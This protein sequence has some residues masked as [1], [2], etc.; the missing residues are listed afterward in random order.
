MDTLAFLDHVQALPSYSGQ[1]VHMERVPE[2]VIE[3]LS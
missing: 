3:L 2:R 1:A